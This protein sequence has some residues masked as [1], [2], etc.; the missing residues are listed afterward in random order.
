MSTIW[1][2]FS[3]FSLISFLEGVKAFVLLASEIFEELK[4][5]GA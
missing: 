1:V 3:L 2:L 5:D 4:A